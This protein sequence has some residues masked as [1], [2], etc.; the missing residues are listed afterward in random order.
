[1]D[2]KYD[3]IETLQPELD[4][5]IDDGFDD[6]FDGDYSEGG[7][8]NYRSGEEAFNDYQAL[9]DE[10]KDIQERLENAQ[11][12]MEKDTMEIPPEGADSK[13]NTGESADDGSAVSDS[14]D[15]ALKSGDSDKSDT[16]GHDDKE[17]KT[18]ESD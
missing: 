2:N 18:D 1:M 8:S 7:E 4:D 14:V 12:E 9:K 16:D 6:D 5:Y 17:S 13:E 11:N 15:D 10:Q 3:D